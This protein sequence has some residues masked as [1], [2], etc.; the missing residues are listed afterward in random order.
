MIHNFDEIQELE[1]NY[2]N[3]EGEYVLKVVDYKIVDT[4]SGNVCHSYICETKD[5]KRTQANLYVTPKALWKY[6]LFLKAL[7]LPHTGNIDVSTLP[8]KIK[9]LK[10][11]GYVAKDEPKEKFNVA[12]GKKEIVESKYFQVERF[13][14][15]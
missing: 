2:I 7:D 9:G 10:F 6:K 5:G 15:C 12:T 14:K 8:E 13:E 11:K 3:E 4:A 1:S